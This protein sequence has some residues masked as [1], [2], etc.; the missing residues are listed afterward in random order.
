MTINIAEW[1]TAALTWLRV[2]AQ[3]PRHFR[4]EAGR[5][6]CLANVGKAPQGPEAWETACQMWS[7]G[8]SLE[9]A[10]ARGAVI[11][12]TADPQLEKVPA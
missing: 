12:A 4:C 3:R 6:N 2:R 1:P 11:R 9:D 7:A 5:R 10:R 8:E